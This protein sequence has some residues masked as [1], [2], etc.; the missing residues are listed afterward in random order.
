MKAKKQDPKTVILPD[1]VKSYYRF[2]YDLTYEEAYAAFSAL[3]FKRGG[4]YRLITGIALTA[5]AVIMLVTYAMDS[6]KI[7]NLTV[8]EGGENRGGISVGITG[9][10]MGYV[11]A[12]LFVSAS[13]V[14][15]GSVTAETAEGN[16]T[17]MAQAAQ[18]TAA[19]ASIEIDAQAVS[20]GQAALAGA[21]QNAD[22]ADISKSYAAAKT[23]VETIGSILS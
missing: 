16:E 9:E 12:E 3:A 6:T 7:M 11:K 1:D 20:F 23:F 10:T 5:A 17:L 18:F 19:F 2:S 21:R 4:N 14:M 15:T 8:E 13:G 22:G